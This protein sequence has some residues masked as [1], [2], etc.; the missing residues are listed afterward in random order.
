MNFGTFFQYSNG[1]L[2]RTESTDEVTLAVAESWLVE[3][4]RVRSMQAHYERFVA[5]VATL[6]AA[7]NPKNV[8]H[9][10]LI[11]FF[12]AVLA[13][14]PEQG[15][16]FPRVEFHAGL[17]N[18][19]FFKLREA[20]DQLGDATIWTYPEPDPRHNPTVKGP[21]LSLGMQLRRK[22]QVH[23]A[24]ETILLS[25]EGLLIEGALSSVVWWRGDVLCAPGTATKW[26]PSITRDEVFAIANQL[27]LTTRVENTRPADLAGCEVWLLSSL[28]GVRRVSAWV[29][30][31]DDD[32][33]TPTL[34][35]A[36][37]AATKRVEAFER[38]LR[39]LSTKPT[40]DRD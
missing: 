9:A 27:G 36:S 7:A 32:T 10:Q 15:R 39:M 20:P 40:L 33:S 8:T 16:W 26:L 14:I 4:G 23:G 28:Q 29:S 24:D 5:G 19:L 11:P 34:A 31:S 35:E 3:D 22:A 12:E 6:D 25:S 18:P 1:R 38:R 13:Q 2:E 30:E 17:A 37:L 21:D